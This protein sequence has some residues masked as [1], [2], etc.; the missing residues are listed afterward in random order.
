MIEHVDATCHCVMAKPA[1]FVADDAKLASLI[2][3]E[4]QHVFVSRLHLN[5]DIHR[6]Q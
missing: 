3:R 1:V 4:R 2:R 6:L 5:I